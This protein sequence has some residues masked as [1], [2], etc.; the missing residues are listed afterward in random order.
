MYSAL[1]GTLCAFALLMSQWT[2]ANPSCVLLDVTSLPTILG[3]SDNTVKTKR[4]SV[5]VYSYGVVFMSCF[6]QISIFMTDFFNSRKKSPKIEFRGNTG[7]LI[8]SW[9]DQEGHKVMFLSEWRELPSAP[10]LAGGK[11]T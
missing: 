8:S 7:V 6:D 11:K 9:P 1:N 5:S 10:C 2:R 4:I 3:A